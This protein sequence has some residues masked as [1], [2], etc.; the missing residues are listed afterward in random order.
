MTS[1]DGEDE[2]KIGFWNINTL[3]QPGEKREKTIS[4]EIKEKNI[5]IMVLG[6]TRRSGSGKTCIDNEDNKKIAFYNGEN[7][8]FSEQ[9]QKRRKQKKT[10]SKAHG[11]VMAVLGD[12]F[13]KSCTKIDAYFPYLAC[14]KEKNKTEYKW[15]KNSYDPPN[16]DFKKVSNKSEKSQ[17]NLDMLV[18]SFQTNKGAFN[19]FCCYAPDTGKSFESWK[20][21]ITCLTEMLA[22][23]FKGK[24]VAICGDLNVE[25]NYEYT[26][27]RFK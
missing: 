2:F 25:F 10:I 5:D 22:K 23:E 9:H 3:G 19:L 16:D 7:H 21:Y 8:T 14:H 1:S 12:N 15:L 13:R 6:E 18:L 24:L 17:A 11:G 26:K 20:T 4:S 27:L